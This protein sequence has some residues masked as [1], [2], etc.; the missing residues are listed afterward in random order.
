MNYKYWFLGCFLGFVLFCCVFFFFVRFLFFCGWF[1]F[2]FFL[3]NRKETYFNVI[4]SR[5]WS[6]QLHCVKL[7][8]ELNMYLLVTQKWLTYIYNRIFCNPESNTNTQE[9][10]N[11]VWIFFLVITCLDTAHAFVILYFR[12]RKYKSIQ[13]DSLQ[14]FII[15]T[16]IKKCLQLIGK[17]QLN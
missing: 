12:R 4:F 2:F 14:L 10:A 11:I 6:P 5:K 13:N 17:P 3:A 8:W 15:T 7:G 16:R 1:F 9:K